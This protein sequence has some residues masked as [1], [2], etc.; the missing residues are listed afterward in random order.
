MAAIELLTAL[1]NVVRIPAPTDLTPVV[2][3]GKPINIDSHCS[4]IQSCSGDLHGNLE[5]FLSIIDQMGLNQGAYVFNDDFVDRGSRGLEVMVS[6][7]ALKLAMPADVHLN[8]GNHEGQ[9]E[10]AP[11]SYL[12]T[13]PPLPY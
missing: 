2:V 10:P 9:P 8:R 11:E 3:V 7:L 4:L 12:P 6:L 5:G 1:P 13:K